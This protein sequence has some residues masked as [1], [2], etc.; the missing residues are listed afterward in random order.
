M[1]ATR[2]LFTIAMLA[3]VAVAVVT[4]V[5]KQTDSSVSTSSPDVD[6]VLNPTNGIVATFYHGNVRCPTCQ[7][8]ERY[9]HDAITR[10]FADEM[11]S[12]EI[13]WKT[14]NYEAP[15]NQPDAERYEIFSSTVVLIR[16][17]DG[18]PADW[19]N[20]NRVWEFVGDEQAFQQYVAQQTREMLET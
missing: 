3:F 4:A 18:K 14:T 8:I 20:L 13:Q 10:N 15:A 19:R 9:A 1:S 5:A 16:M 6:A 2:K 7:N 11:A 12:G 17:V